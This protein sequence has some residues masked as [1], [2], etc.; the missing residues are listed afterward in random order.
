MN[1]LVRM[2]DVLISFVFSVTHVL[3]NMKLV[4]LENK[5]FFFFFHMQSLFFFIDVISCL[6]ISR[7]SYFPMDDSS[8]FY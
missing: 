6:F 5:I 4:V 8:F 7:N 3:F 1:Y 2:C